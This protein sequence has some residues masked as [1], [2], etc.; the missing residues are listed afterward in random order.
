MLSYR[1]TNSSILRWVLD[2][3]G[4]KWYFLCVFKSPRLVCVSVFISFRPL[5]LQM[6]IC[7]EVTHLRHKISP[8]QHT[9]A[10]AIYLYIQDHLKI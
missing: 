10:T 6:K 5:W 8:P 3:K 2:K 9:L 1:F 4:G 7:S